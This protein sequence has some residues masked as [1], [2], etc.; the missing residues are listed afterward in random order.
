MRHLLFLMVLFLPAIEITLAADDLTQLRISA[1][2][3]AVLDGRLL[4]SVPEQAKLRPMQHGIMSA[5]ESDS[6]QTRI[7]I[8]AGQQRMVLMAYELFARASESDLEG[9]AQ[10]IISHFPM[11]VSLQKWTLLAPLRAVA[12]FPT[13]PTNN[14]EANLVMGV[15]VVNSDGNVQNLMWYV[16]PAAASQFDT[17]LKLAKSMAATI[18]PGTKTLDTT[19]GERELS[20]YSK[21]KS[22]FAKIPKNYTLT[23]QHGPDFVVHHINKVVAFGD[24]N[25][26]MGVYLGDHPSSNHNGFAEQEKAT[27][28]GKSVHWYQKVENEDGAKVITVDA[29][30]PL[31]WALLGNSMPGTSEGASYADVFLTAANASNIEELKS[32]ALTLSI[33]DGNGKR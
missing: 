25:A 14:E 8:D 31:G 28:F 24:E 2:K 26:S 27:L 30:I 33:R 7:V 13:N 11:K 32:I 23:A 15:F 1:T 10:K 29:T 21:T 3:T 12:Y 18:A 20:A 22:V 4:V 16:N 19:G 17:A 5:P 9:P 6:E